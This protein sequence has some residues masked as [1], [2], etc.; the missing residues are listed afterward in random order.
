VTT[1]RPV[2]YG[3]ADAARAYVAAVLGAAGE[4]TQLGPAY[5]SAAPQVRALPRWPELRAALAAMLPGV[6][7]ADW[8]EVTMPELTGRDERAAWLAAHHRAVVV[9]SLREGTRRPVGPGVLAEA[10]AFAAA[11][12]PVLVFTGRR[13][14]AWPDCRTR[15]APTR[16]GWPVAVWLDVPDMPPRPLPTLAASLRALGVADP[17]AIARASGRAPG[18]GPAPSPRPSPPRPGPPMPAWRP[19][20]ARNHA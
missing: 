19:A 18:G 5:L 9:V 10:Q 3:T 8:S 12:R 14:A 17:A 4:L 6:P 11:S 20:Q 1:R 2:T 13:L 15:P 16:R 7:L